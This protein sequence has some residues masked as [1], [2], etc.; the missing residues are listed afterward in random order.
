MR[1]R[2]PAR[3]LL[4]DQEGTF[5]T[6]RHGLHLNWDRRNDPVRATRGFDFSISQ[7]LAGLGG[8]VNYLRTELDC[9]LYYGCRGQAGA[10]ASAAVAGYISGWGGDDVRINDRFFKGGASFRGFD[11]AGI[12]PRQL[13]VDDATGEIISRATR[14]AA[15]ST[16]SAPFSSMCRTGAETFG[17]DAALFADFGTFGVSRSVERRHDR[18]RG[19]QQL[20]RRG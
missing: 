20:D 10:R 18:H 6:S 13:L 17:L 19:R 2:Q 7:D 4:C 3:P 15:M 1:S 12:G 8:E 5:L 14:S 16:R 9:G 11:V